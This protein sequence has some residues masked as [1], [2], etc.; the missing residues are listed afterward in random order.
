MLHHRHQLDVR[1][2]EV[3]DVGAELLGRLRVGEA[4]PPGAEVHLVDRDGAPERQAR[5]PLE[6]PVAVLPFVARAEHDRRGPRRHLARLR[7]RI[8]AKLHAPVAVAN[9]ELVAGGVGD[10]RD[11]QLPDARGAE[12]AHRVD[13]AVPIV[14]V[15][16]DADRPRRRSP[17]REGRPGDAVD[18]AHVR[19]EPLV[20]LLVT[21]FGRKVQ[22]DLAES[23]QERIRVVELDRRS[24]RVGHL[25]AVAE[26]QR[27]LRQAALEH[28]RGMHPLQL[29]AAVALRLHRHLLGAGAE[30][31]HDDMVACL[32]R[33]EH[34]VG[35]RMIPFDQQVEVD[36]SHGCASSSRRRTPL[37]GIETQSG[38][39]SSSYP[40]S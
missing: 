38:L 24:V 15:A 17:D 11:E 29:D 37:T 32:V 4:L 9:L 7:H 20:Q 36:G 28:A 25:E 8:G 16:D 13:A 26:R 40:S 3:A 31:P 30:G 21:A 22:V 14:E 35:S 19:A 18:L 39:C 34:V 12:R 27:P 23:R 1:E 5:S 33:P 2:A 10:A 6:L